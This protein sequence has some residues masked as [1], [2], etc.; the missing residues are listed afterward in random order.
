MTS[1]PPPLQCKPARDLD[2]VDQVM[3]APGMPHE[4]ET[5]VIGGR[6]HRV[7][8]HL[9]ASIRNFWAVKTAAL[10][11]NVYAIK[12]GDRVGICSK[13]CPEY[14]IVF[15][16]CHLLGA[17][18]VLANAHVPFPSL[19]LA[20]DATRQMASL[21]NFEG[22]PYQLKMDMGNL[23]QRAG[24]TGFL[25]FDYCS[26]GNGKRGQY[27]F[28]KSVLRD[29]EI[30]SAQKTAI[31]EEHLVLLPED[32]ATILF[33]SGTVALTE[34]QLLWG[35]QRSNQGQPGNPRAFCQHIANGSTT[36]LMLAT[37]NGSKII[38]MPKWDAEHGLIFAQVPPSVFLTGIV[39]ARLIKAENVA[40]AG[41]VPAMISDL[42]RSSLVGYPL[43]GLLTGGSPLPESLARRAQ[44]SFPTAAVSQ[45]YGLTEI[46]CTAASI[47]GE[48]FV[49]RPDSTGRACPVNDILI[50]KKNKILAPGELG[51]IWLR[52]PNVMKEYWNDPVKDVIIRGGENI[53]SV[54]V[55]NALYADARVLE[56]AAIAVH[57]ERLGELPAAVVYIAPEFRGQVTEASLI[58]LTK[59]KLPKF[60][61]PVLIVFADSPFGACPD[62]LQ[63][64][65]DY[66]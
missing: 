42:L 62:V 57:D 47:S 63:S 12:K 13:N 40:L 11:R 36:Y 34:Q 29:S 17:V 30:A 32:N 9:W 46:N 18:T 49:D 64:K 60:A 65:A 31:L 21:G 24:A 51:E 33:T 4:M 8:K 2:E 7:Y 20:T 56:A 41:G 52:G 58:A 3:C 26:V 38:L 37:M 22:L 25:V 59:T 15:W 55:E 23:C 10:F 45:V 39:A 66:F 19:L 43:Q 27:H 54:T 53:A 6:I 61:V 50:V 28:L 16:A 35:S 48:D 44:A 5:L 14:I 1:P